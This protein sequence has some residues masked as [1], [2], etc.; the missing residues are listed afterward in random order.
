METKFTPAE[1][2]EEYL[3]RI[4]ALTGAKQDD[5]MALTVSQPGGCAS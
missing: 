1:R 2:A 3:E 5:P 4:A